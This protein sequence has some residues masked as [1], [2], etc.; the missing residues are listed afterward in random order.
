MWDGP[1]ATCGRTS[2]FPDLTSLL[3]GVVDTMSV[4]EREIQDREGRWYSMRIRPYRTMDNKIDGAVMIFIDIDAARRIHLELQREQGFTAAVLESAAALVMVTDLEGRIVRFNLAC[5]RLSGYSF[6]EVEAKP[7]WDVL[8]PPEE[9]EA[10]KQMYQ[11]LSESRLV[12]EHESNWVDRNGQR[13]L[14]SWSSTAVA[15]AGD[16]ASTYRPGRS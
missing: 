15:E 7:V 9:I 11:E 13:H 16:G 1:S 2:R 5:Q 8:V 4:R 3:D 12:R 14:I 10:V 6:E